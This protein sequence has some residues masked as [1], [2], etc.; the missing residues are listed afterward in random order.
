[1]AAGTLAVVALAAGCGSLQGSG[2]G[3][4]GSS[5]DTSS[6]NSSTATSATTGSVSG[7]ASVTQ[8]GG[9]SGSGGGAAK[10]PECKSADLNLG[11]GQSDGTAGTVYIALQFTNKS[12]S[13]CVLVGFPGVS[14]VGN[15]NGQQVGAPAVRDGG[16]GSQVTLKPGQLAS[17]IVGMVD[18]SVFDP[19]VC[20]PTP[21]AG[22]RVYPPDE[23]ASMF[24]ALQNGA[25]GCAGT[26]PDPQLKVQT[27]K[28]GPGAP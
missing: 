21:V 10:T 9:S 19:A 20:K 12:R 4:A 24:V 18:I 6:S 5:T 14:Y 8:S 15:G 11:L 7:A 25:M 17:S 2:S 1:V 26:T 27:I 13:N 23:T 3:S 22:F 28:A 16:I